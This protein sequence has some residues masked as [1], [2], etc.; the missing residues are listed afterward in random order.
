MKILIVILLAIIAFAVAGPFMMGLLTVILWVIG[1]FIAI[2]ILGFILEWIGENV[3]SD[4]PCEKEASTAIEDLSPQF[5]QDEATREPGGITGN[6][7]WFQWVLWVSV[8]VCLLFL[9]VWLQK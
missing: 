4:S 1:I 2:A 3:L 5:K 7:V 8:A 9:A 6:E